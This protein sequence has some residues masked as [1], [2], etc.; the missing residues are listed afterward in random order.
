M[1]ALRISIFILLVLN[2]LVPVIQ[3]CTKDS[4]KTGNSAL[5]NLVDTYN[6]DVPFE[7]DKAVYLEGEM[8]VMTLPSKE[9]L[10][11]LKKE[12]KPTTEIF[13]AQGTSL[14]SNPD[15]ALGKVKVAYLHEAVAIEA[16]N[17]DIYT[18]TI[19]ERK[20]DALIQNLTP[21]WAGKGFGLAFWFNRKE[22]PS[23][24]AQ[25]ASTD[26]LYGN[27]RATAPE[28]KCKVY[29]PN[30]TNDPDC[31]SGGVGATSCSI[32][33]VET[34]AGCSVSCESQNS[35]YTCCKAGPGD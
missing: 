32:A 14:P 15:K 30:V 11:F 9:V 27:L 20:G 23:D 12:N 16:E 2:I 10:F 17:G 8:T 7:Q 21:A 34:V 24:F 5:R 26:D 22:T 3:S 28:C 33:T 35:Y 4:Q 29:D 13:L 25:L 1:K 31:T 19:G 6:K 18:F